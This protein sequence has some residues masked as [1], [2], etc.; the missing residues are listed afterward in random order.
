[1]QRLCCICNRELAKDENY[2]KI[3]GVRYWCVACGYQWLKDRYQPYKDRIG[4][5]LRGYHG[6]TGT[7]RLFP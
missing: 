6:P 7:R 1:M 5:A 4:E 2:Y 3:D